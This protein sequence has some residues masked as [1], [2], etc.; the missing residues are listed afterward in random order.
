MTTLSLPK[1]AAKSLA[2]AYQGGRLDPAEY[3]NRFAAVGEA[4]KQLN[5]I[6]A[7]GRAGKAKGWQDTRLVSLRS[8]RDWADAITQLLDMRN[9]FERIYRGEASYA[10]PAPS[11]AAMEKHCARRD[12]CGPPCTLR[13]RGL[14]LRKRCVPALKMGK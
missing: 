3:R 11:R 1:Q 10:L 5:R 14:G 6:I 12:P 13:R 7:N 4:E 9:T 2:A 8:A